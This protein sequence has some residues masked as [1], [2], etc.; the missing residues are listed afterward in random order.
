MTTEKEQDGRI[1]YANTKMVLKHIKKEL[2][3]GS[4]VGE[5]SLTP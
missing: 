3:S 1:V 4:D 5:I 2:H